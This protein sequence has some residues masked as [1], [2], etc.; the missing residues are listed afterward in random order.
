MISVVIPVYREGTGVVACLRALSDNTDQCVVV[1][2]SE[3]EMFQLCRS[4]TLN[5]LPE[6]NLV[7]LAAVSK[8]R[9]AQMN[10]GALNSHG[11]VLVFL[12]ADTRLP[13]EAFTAIVNGLDSGWHW[14]RFDVCFDNPRWWYSLISS[15]MNV[16][17]RMSGIATGDQA[18]FMTR[19]AYDLVSGFDEIQLMEDIAMSKKIENHRQALMP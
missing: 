17:S 5:A 2:A 8:G 4:E 14:G 9:A 7:Y 12:H 1:D 3:S 15:M 19:A 18:L 6:L 16:R 13:E 11:D 10:Q